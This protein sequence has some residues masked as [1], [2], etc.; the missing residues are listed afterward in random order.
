[1]RFWAGTSGYSYKEWKGS[2]YPEKLPAKDML[3]HY[4]QQLPVVEINNTFY[5]MPSADV[6]RGWLEQVPDSFRFVIKA[7]RRIT[8]LKRMKAVEEE[9]QYLL[10][11]L[12]ALEDRLGAVL[13]QLPPNLKKDMSRLE[14]FMTLLSRGVRSAFEFRHESWFDDEVRACLRENDCAMCCADT[15][16]DDGPGA[17]VVHATASWGYVRLRRP[18]YTREELAAWGARLRGQ[19]WQDAFVFFK[20]EDE[21]GGPR[22]A[23]EFLDVVNDG[24]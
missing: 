17:G 8:H 21:A 7:S 4:A 15:G 22:M 20:H 6:L 12:E 1:M 19:G 10:E 24:G 18:E 2:F 13:Y 16:D 5:R 3:R 11:T 9:T 23:R 14:P